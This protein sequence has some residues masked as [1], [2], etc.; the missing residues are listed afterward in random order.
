VQEEEKDSLL[1]KHKQKLTQDQI[2]QRIKDAGHDIGKSTIKG[3]F[4]K[5]LYS[6]GNRLEYDFG[7]IKTCD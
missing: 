6:L 1:G 3:C 2:Y 5:Q 4:I 7:E